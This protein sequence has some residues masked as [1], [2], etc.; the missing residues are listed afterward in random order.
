YE[1]V[2][3][4]VGD[5]AVSPSRWNVELPRDLHALMLQ[6]LDKDPA[7]RPTASDVERALR[8]QLQPAVTRAAERIPGS[9][10]VGRERERTALRAAF[11]EVA[12]GR[13]L[14][15]CVAGEPGI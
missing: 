7:R 13:S 6:M 5:Q 4:I 11:D 9:N 1:V 12:A 2:L 15:I 14:M 10:R 3:A 8:A